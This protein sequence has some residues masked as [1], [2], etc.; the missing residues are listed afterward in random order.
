ML[1]AY[2][3][4]YIHTYIHVIIY[5]YIYKKTDR[6]TDRPLD[7]HEDRHLHVDRPWLLE[8][9]AMKLL[10]LLKWVNKSYVGLY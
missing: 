10:R 6:Q 3:H 9:L 8:L 5:T 4:T 7:T 1:H 2:I